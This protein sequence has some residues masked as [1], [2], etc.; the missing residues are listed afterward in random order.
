[1]RNY[2]GCPG[3][4][5]E[6]CSCPEAG[7][8]QATKNVYTTEFFAKCPSNGARIKYRLRI[9][10]LTMIRVESIVATVSGITEGYHEDIADALLSLGGAQILTADH[11]GVTIETTRAAE[12]WRARGE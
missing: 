10:A 6:F 9:E 8:V 11:H 7:A 12:A 1:M 3:R 5:F 2:C 4:G